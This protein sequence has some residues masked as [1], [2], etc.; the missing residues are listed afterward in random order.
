[1]GSLRKP[2]SA[3]STPR[4]PCERESSGTPVGQSPDHPNACQCSLRPSRPHL[5]SRHHRLAEGL[6]RES[7]CDGWCQ[8]FLARPPPSCQP[9][10]LGVRVV[11]GAQLPLHSLQVLETQARPCPAVQGLSRPSSFG[12]LSGAEGPLVPIVPKKQLRKHS[13]S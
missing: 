5:G 1:M 9:P 7:C 2:S 13:C 3:S 8:L 11:S 10:Q 6:R 4:K 12:D